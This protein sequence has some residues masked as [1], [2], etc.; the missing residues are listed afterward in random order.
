MNF[1]PNKGIFDGII[2]HN[3]NLVLFLMNLIFNLGFQEACKK[4]LKSIRK[5]SKVR[6]RSTE[7]KS[8]VL[9]KKSKKNQLL[10]AAE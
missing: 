6:S 8:I 2:I 1:K 10:K 3:V 5:W 7:I 9:K 4:I